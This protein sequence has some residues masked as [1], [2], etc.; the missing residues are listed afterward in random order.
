MTKQPWDE[1]R[2][3]HPSDYVEELVE[4]DYYM[5]EVPMDWSRKHLKDNYTEEQIR[6][7]WWYEIGR[8]SE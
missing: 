1:D 6:E 3:M 5:A 4:L 2:G 8:H 7:L